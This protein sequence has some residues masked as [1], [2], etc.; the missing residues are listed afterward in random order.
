MED[1]DDKT[2]SNMMGIATNA[3][4]IRTTCAQVNSAQCSWRMAWMVQKNTRQIRGCHENV[5][6]QSFEKSPHLMS[7]A[8]YPYYGHLNPD[9][10]QTPEAGYKRDL[11]AV[12]QNHQVGAFSE[13]LNEHVLMAPSDLPCIFLPSKP[14]CMNIV[15]NMQDSM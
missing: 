5:L 9:L 3:A 13:P 4:A 15:T 12:D 10:V 11:G 14:S 8:D 6:I 2:T 7:L 1:I